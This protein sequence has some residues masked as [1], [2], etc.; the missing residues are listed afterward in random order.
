MPQ[1]PRSGWYGGWKPKPACAIA[2]ADAT[3]ASC[4]KRSS[5]RASLTDRWSVGSNSP[6]DPAPSTIPTVPAAQRSWRVEAPM[7][8][9]VTAPRPVITTRRFNSGG[10]RRDQVDG[11]ADG[12]QLLH[13][14]ALEDDA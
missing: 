4:E 12:L 7:P 10:P 6:H 2:S 1:P 5:R 3:S 14:L 13:V 9:G 11:V 8:R